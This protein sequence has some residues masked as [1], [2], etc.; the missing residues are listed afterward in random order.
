MHM[1]LPNLPFI[2]PDPL[3]WSTQ[4][5]FPYRIAA[6][7]IVFF[8]ARLDGYHGDKILMRHLRMKG[9]C[10][11]YIDWILGGFYCYYSSIGW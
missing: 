6:K 5:I 10:D 7:G 8:S 1:K 4:K 2:L 3:H 11:G 9:G